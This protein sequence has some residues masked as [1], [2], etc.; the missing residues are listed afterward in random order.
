[1][2]WRTEVDEIARRRELAKEM[3]GP[4][5]I[6]QHHQAG[7]L[8]VRERIDMLLDS[9]SFR[10][11]GILTGAAQYD[12]KGNLIGFMPANIVIGTGLIARRRVVVSGEDFTICG[13]SSDATSPKKWQW[14]DCYF[15][16]I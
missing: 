9:S 16:E 15:A 13:G 4:E 6:A 10:E 2:S 11:F 5:N 12:D 3:G 7:K 14:G 8:T 1:M